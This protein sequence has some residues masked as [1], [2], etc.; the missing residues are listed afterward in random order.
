MNLLRDGM[1]ALVS[2]LMCHEVQSELPDPESDVRTVLLNATNSKLFQF[3]SRE[4]EIFL[5]HCG[6]VFRPN[7]NVVGIRPNCVWHGM[8]FDEMLSP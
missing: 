4:L 3:H 1:R 6:I 8:F 5:V 7:Y 2:Q